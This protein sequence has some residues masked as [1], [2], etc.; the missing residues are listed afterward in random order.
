M[1]VVG[2]QVVEHSIHDPSSDGG[3]PPP[4][5]QPDGLGMG[6]LASSSACYTF[7]FFNVQPGFSASTQVGSWLSLQKLFSLLLLPFHLPLPLPLP[8]TVAMFC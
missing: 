3:P 2:A 6:D 8:T 7:F 4:C 5:V 1:I